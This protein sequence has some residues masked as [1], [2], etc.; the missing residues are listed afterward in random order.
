MKTAEERKRNA[1]ERYHRLYRTPEYLKKAAKRQAARRALNPEYW[2]SLSKDYL[3]AKR[4]FIQSFKQKPC[5]DCGLFYPPWVMDFDHTRDKKFTISQ[6]AKWSKEELKAEIVK[7][8]VVCA[9]CHR[10]RTHA[11][12]TTVVKN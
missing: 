9:N 8:D 5:A 12:S 10:E 1:R 6:C 3:R 2:A 4:I 11:N 7:C